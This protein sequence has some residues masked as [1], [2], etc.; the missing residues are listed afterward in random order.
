MTKLEIMRKRII[1]V[2]P[3]PGWRAQVEMMPAKQVYAIYNKFKAD[4]SFT[5]AKCKRMQDTSVQI[6]IWD[7]GIDLYV[8]GSN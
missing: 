5:K 6:S 7:L 2:Y 4:G 3:Y 1:S 8:K